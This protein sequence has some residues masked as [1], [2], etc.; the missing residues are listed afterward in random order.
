MANPVGAE[1]EARK[2]NIVEALRNHSKLFTEP[3]SSPTDPPT[4]RYMLRGVCTEP[5][6]TYVL[7]RVLPNEST[8]GGA[9]Q[10]WRISF[11]TDDAK[12]QEAEKNAQQSNESGPAAPRNADVIGYT[13][14]K[15]REIEV[16]RAAREESRGVLLVYA[17]EN[18]MNIQ[19]GPLPP[20]LQVS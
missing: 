1:L 5:H 3:S 7:R 14:R 4:H 8:A 20:Q 13:T 18:A 11:S 17:S 6:I 9:W 19:E 16:L 15:V 10:W 12:T 2:A